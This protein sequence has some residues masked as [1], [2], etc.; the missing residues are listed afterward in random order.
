MSAAMPTVGMRC[1]AGGVFTMGS[2]HFYPKERPCRRVR[3]DEFWIDATP[4]RTVDAFDS[5]M[6]NAV[7]RTQSVCVGAKSAQRA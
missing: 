2:E 3:V 4:G 1:L 6:R 5:Q 7:A